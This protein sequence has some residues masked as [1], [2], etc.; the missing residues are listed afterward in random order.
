M[1]A[2]TLK[3]RAVVVLG[4]IFG[5]P[6][7]SSFGRQQRLSEIT[8]EPIENLGVGK[9]WGSCAPWPSG[10]TTGP[11]DPRNAR[12]YGGPKLQ[13]YKNLSPSDVFFQA[14]NAPK[15]VFGWGSALDPR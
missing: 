13:K 6:G 12:A 5:G 14:P 10:V 11:A 3:K 9:I 2:Y 15:A 1:V 8:I 4:K 7:P